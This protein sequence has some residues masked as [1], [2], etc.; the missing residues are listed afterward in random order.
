MLTADDDIEQRTSLTERS[1]YHRH[2]FVSN[3]QIIVINLLTA[4]IDVFFTANG[5]RYIAQMD[6]SQRFQLFQL[7]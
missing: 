7:R 3:Q 5:W 4:A 6:G 1:Q 2:N